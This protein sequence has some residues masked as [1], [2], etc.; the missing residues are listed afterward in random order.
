MV[1]TLQ[2][3]CLLVSSTEWRRHH[4]EDETAGMEKPNPLIASHDKSNLWGAR[5]EQILPSLRGLEVRKYPA[6]GE[7]FSLDFPFY[8][9]SQDLAGRRTSPCQQQRHEPSDQ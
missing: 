9:T 5:P 2:P 7:V 1:G 8:R 3:S 4:H 6:A